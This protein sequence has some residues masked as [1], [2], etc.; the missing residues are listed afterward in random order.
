MEGKMERVYFAHYVEARK[1]GLTVNTRVLP[2]LAKLTLNPQAGSL[3][4]RTLNELVGNAIKY[5]NKAV[6][7]GQRQVSIYVKNVGNFLEFKVWDNGRGMDEEELSN[8]GKTKWRSPHVIGD[9]IEGSGLGIVGL[10]DHVEKHLGGT[11]SVESKPEIGR[12]S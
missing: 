10:I 1:K 6:P 8:F 2:A 11:Y 7:H 9:E 5:H 3:L 4:E 12:A